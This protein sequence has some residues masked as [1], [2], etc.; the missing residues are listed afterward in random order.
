MREMY[1]GCVSYRIMYSETRDCE[2]NKRKLQ[3][4]CCRLY[5]FI[6]W[7][8][9]KEGPGNFSGGRSPHWVNH[10]N[11]CLYCIVYL[12]CF[13]STFVLFSAPRSCFSNN[14]KERHV[15]V[16]HGMSRQGMSRKGITW[17]VK[18]R[19]GKVRQGNAWQGKAWHVKAMHGMSIQGKV[20]QGKA[21]HVKERHVKARQ[22]MERQGK[23]FLRSTKCQFCWTPGT[24]FQLGGP[25]SCDFV[26]QKS[27]C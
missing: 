16:R 22:G 20:C 9:I 2:I 15:K 27:V 25:L 13:V 26:A 18:T 14:V 12:L 3:L 1:C 6:C 4:V 19:H 23:L 10:V 24:G 8:I 17:H 5:P 7:I 11:L 21:R